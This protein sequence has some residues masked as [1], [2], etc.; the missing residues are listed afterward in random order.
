MKRGGIT[1][2]IVAF[3]CFAAG[4]ALAAETSADP[5]WPALLEQRK[6]WWSFQPV[7]HP[8]LPQVN[9][10]AWPVNAID[11]FLLSRMEGVGLTPSQEA[12]KQ[13][14][15]RRASFVLT[16]LPPSPAEMDAFLQDVTPS[17][18]LHAVDRLLASS[19]FGE[20]WAQHW[21]DLARFS[22]TYGSEHDALI[23]HAWRYRDY[24]VR[25]FNDDVP[26]DRFVREQIA[27][28]L[29]PPRWNRS[30][31]INESP[32]GTAF[33]RFVEFYPTPTD[34]KA[35]EGTVIESEVDAFGKTFQGLTLACARC[36]DHKFDPVSAADY[37][38]LYGSR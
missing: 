22:D 29:L 10:S 3:A 36:H 2:A 38:A 6:Q 23:P 16:G 18:Y 7:E 28:D 34:P 8:P 14:L 31:G 35:E 20:R 26:Y 32:A 5:K 11:R 27:G 21:M 30:L 15:L 13:T 12:A 19:C 37:Y 25:A 4:R 1:N 9:R 24:L 33:L 17:A